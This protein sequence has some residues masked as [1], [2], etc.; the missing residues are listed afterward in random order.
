MTSS[1]L[2]VPHCIW[3]LGPL[4]EIWRDGCLFRRRCDVLGK[5]Y[6]QVDDLK[7]QVSRV[8]SIRQHE[9][10]IDKIFSETQQPEKPQGSTAVE[11]QSMSIRAINVN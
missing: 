6:H 5:L 9:S 2:Q 8:C 3:C 1:F 11:M 4:S 7:Q 10:E